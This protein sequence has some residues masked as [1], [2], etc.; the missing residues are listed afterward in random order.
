MRTL[1]YMANEP[2]L[3][4]F[5]EFSGK[6]LENVPMS[7][8]TTFRVGGAADYMILPESTSELITAVQNLKKN[9]I[10]YYIIGKGSNLL[11]LDKGIRGAIIKLSDNFSKIS[12]SD[13]IVTAAS[14]TLLGELVRD[15]HKNGLCGMETLGGIPGTVGGAVVMN[16]G[17]Y[18]G[19]I[20]DFI[21]SINA[22]DDSSNIITLDK[23]SLKL[24]YRTSSILSRGLI[25]LD[26]SFTLEFGDINAAKE[27]L[28]DYNNKRR[29]KQPIDFPSAG[30]T[31]KR[32]QGHFAGKLIED[33]GLK[34]FSIGGAQVSEKHA[35]F[36]INKGEATACDIINLIDYVRKTVSDKFG[37]DLEPEVKIIGEA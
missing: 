37:V 14:G 28:R 25:V 27:R 15:S 20:A 33:A 8:H 34:G 24:G 19:Q 10:P 3:K 11:V 18:G 2:F 5:T 17:A 7:K 29:E 9:N 26:A 16:A 4:S 21:L 36:I 22:I 32:P 31:F 23:G 12:F 6:I 30:S 35:G 1:K 13:N